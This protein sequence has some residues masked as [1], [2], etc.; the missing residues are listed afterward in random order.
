MDGTLVDSLRDIA[1]ATN[2][3]LELLGVPVISIPSYRYLVGDGIVR[4][5][6]RAIGET[7]PELVS[8]LIE[9][10][11]ARYRLAPL[12]HTRPYAGVPDL[13]S[14]VQSAGKKL[15]VLSNKPHELTQRITRTFWPNDFHAIQG[16]VEDRLRKPNPHF[17]LQMCAALGVAPQETCLIGDTPTDVET[18]RQAGCQCIGITWGFRTRA[19]LLEAGAT[20]IA[21]TP[22]AVAK[23]L[24]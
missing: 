15:G 8:R 6:Q 7:H 5:A 16:Y 22:E 23:L 9:L 12:K 24:L 11:R 2:E 13:V 10:T 4:L 17:I 20:V 18:A 1:D 14:Q 19:D 21:D 3:C